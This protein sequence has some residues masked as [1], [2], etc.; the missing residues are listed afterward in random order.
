MEESGT[1]QTGVLDNAEADGTSKF[2]VDMDLI[3]AARLEDDD[4]L[5]ALN[6]GVFNQE[7]LEQGKATG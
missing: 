7:D 5:K 2:H 3:P 6:I 1:I 4:D